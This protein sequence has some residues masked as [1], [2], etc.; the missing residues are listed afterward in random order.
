MQG[1]SLFSHLLATQ[2]RN[3][4]QQQ[5]QAQQQQQQQRQQQSLSAQHGLQQQQPPLNTVTQP[6][7][8]GR[9]YSNSLFATLQ[10][11]QQQQQ[12]QQT[13]QHAG[14]VAS[15]AGLQ[16]QPHGSMPQPLGSQAQDAANNLSLLPP[17][18]LNGKY[19]LGS[20]GSGMPLDSSAM[21]QAALMQHS[22]NMAQ[23]NSLSHAPSTSCQPNPAMDPLQNPM[24]AQSQHP[25]QH[26]HAPTQ[27]L[28]KLPS[29]SSSAL[30]RP[31]LPTSSSAGSHQLHPGWPGG[32]SNAG[33]LQHTW[34]GGYQ[35][36]HGT[37]S[38]PAAA[39]QQPILQRVSSGLDRLA[40][41][42]H[43]QQQQQQQQQQGGSI[44]L[45]GT[46]V[47]GQASSTPP[48]LHSHILDNLRR[49][50]PQS[51]VAYGNLPH[52]E[53][54]SAMAQAMAGS[55]SNLPLSSGL[56]DFSRASNSGSS[57]PNQAP[58]HRMGSQ[59]PLQGGLSSAPTHAGASQPK[60]HASGGWGNAGNT[61]PSMPTAAR[62]QLQF[63]AAQAGR[64][65]EL[66]RPPS[67]HSHHHGTLQ[68]GPS[69]SHGED[70]D[71]DG[72]DDEEYEDESDE[73]MP[74]DSS[75]QLLGPGKA[76]EASA[77]SPG[78]HPASL[79]RVSLNAAP[80][81][82]ASACTDQG[83]GIGSGLW[84]LLGSISTSLQYGGQDLDKPCK[85]NCIS[86]HHLQACSAQACTI[87]RCAPCSLHEGM[88]IFISMGRS[89][90]SGSHRW[91]YPGVI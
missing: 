24:W 4:Q 41:M 67:M 39:L 53:A 22:A 57:L 91:P 7:S 48:N 86:E 73:G 59:T 69:E 46:G 9:P 77:Y 31:A 33:G 15:Q 66:P 80:L 19:A 3:L 35:S 58:I 72:D 2:H 85:L 18:Q 78:L 20:L 26:A 54:P 27:L 55:Q 64:P 6:P 43:F 36:Q 38:P 14:S 71:G 17:Y 75:E 45:T 50:L 70:P 74:H 1:N 28:G 79:H 21:Q 34:S 44:P 47:A 90:V 5:Q 11:H 89:S 81:P 62:S 68:L 88:I 87:L 32:T 13:Q 30:Q 25:G 63:P 12:Q 52:T 82:T 83:I 16:M 8:F 76:A 56:S 61:A 23:P 37:P 84:Q 42:R 40:L 65:Q 60:A 51:S 10:Q 29:S 49:S